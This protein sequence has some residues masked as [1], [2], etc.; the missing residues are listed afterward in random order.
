MPEILQ[1]CPCSRVWSAMKKGEDI[2]QRGTRWNVARN[3]EL[4]FWFDNWCSDGPLRSLVQGPLSLEEEKLKVK[5]VV[6]VNGWDWSKISISMPDNVNTKLKATP[7]SL[8]AQLQ[9]RLTWG[10]STHRGFELKSAYKLPLW[11][12]KGLLL[13]L[14]NGFGKP[15]SSLVFR[16]LCGCACTIV[17]A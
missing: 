8:A 11:V 6:T 2:F 14:A 13:L 7:V 5:E 3:S 12:R 1:S 10:M 4:S 15:T 9:D 16:L 17:L